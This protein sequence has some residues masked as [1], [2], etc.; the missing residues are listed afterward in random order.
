MTFDE[1]PIVAV[2]SGSCDGAISIIRGS[3]QGCLE[4]LSPFLQSFSK[5]LSPQLM[6]AN[7]LKR[8]KFVSPKKNNEVI[9]DIVAVAFIGPHSY[10]GEDSFE[11]YFHGSAYIIEKALV[12]LIGNNN[13]F[14]MAQP[15]EFTRRSYL[16][17]KIDLTQAEGIESLISSETEHQWKAARSLAD[18][19]L[20]KHIKN[21]RQTLIDALAFLEAR[22]DFP[23]EEETSHIQYDLITNKVDLV[24]NSLKELIDRYDSGRIASEGLKV[25]FVGEP[26]AGKSTLLNL[27]LEQERSIV[28]DIPG[29]TRDYVKEKFIID[30]K[31][32]T[33]VDTA[34]LRSKTEDKVEKIGMD[35]TIEQAK[36]A[37]V[38][39][40][41]IP[42]T[43]SLDEA[44][45]NLKRWLVEIEPKNYCVLI[46]KADLKSFKEQLSIQQYPISSL[47]NEGIDAV[48]KKLCSY[49]GEKCQ[50]IETSI[51]IT[52]TRHKVAIENA[53]AAIQ[54]FYQAL[55]EEQFDEILAFELKNAFSALSEV[56]GHVTSDDLLDV[57][58]SNFCLGK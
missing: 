46:T 13:G 15:G 34:G 6:Q 55:A 17:G 35:R 30:G 48:K 7:V 21:L 19:R 8:Y 41:L 1:E 58:F 4:L 44:Q 33:L 37:D 47:H 16:N 9:D 25:C 20:K 56:I 2:A 32:F 45:S 11:L 39:L 31:L 42:S 43:C 50:A 53:F 14:R 54:Q 40:F 51:L 52:N 28:T 36:I 18:G 49:Y 26:N 5:S 22:I 10:T 29:T 38:V 24:K 27:L 23:D 12:A 57:V 3:G